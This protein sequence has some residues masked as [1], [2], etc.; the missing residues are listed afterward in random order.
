MEWFAEIQAKQDSS[1]DNVTLDLV[2]EM[3][4]VCASRLHEIRPHDIQSATLVY[5][6]GNHFGRLWTPLDLGHLRI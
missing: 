6:L 1:G 4:K 3:V 2:P 5:S